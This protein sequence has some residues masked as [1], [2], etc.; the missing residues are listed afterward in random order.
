M[1]VCQHRTTTR[2]LER[3]LS[4]LIF[5]YL[6]IKPKF[7]KNLY[8]KPKFHTNLY[9]KSKFYKTLYREPKFHKNLYRKP[10]FYFKN[11]YR[12]PKFHKNLY[13]KPKFHKSLRRMITLHK[14]RFSFIIIFYWILLRTSNISDK[15]RNKT[16]YVQFFFCRKL[17]FMGKCV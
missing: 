2:L 4:N 13:S 3:I 10:N 12:K 9:R 17:S 15:R 11:L 6:Y 5:D 7:H 16:N 14:T 1:S 8:R